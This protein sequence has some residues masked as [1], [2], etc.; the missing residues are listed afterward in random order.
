MHPSWTQ[1]PQNEQQLSTNWPK[2]LCARS[3]LDFGQHSVGAN[4]LHYSFMERTCASKDTTEV[5]WKLTEFVIL[6]G[7]SSFS[8]MPIAIFKGLISLSVEWVG[9]MRRPFL[10]FEG[11][12]MDMS[13]SWEG[14]EEP[15]FLFWRRVTPAQCFAHP[16][17]LINVI[18][19]CPW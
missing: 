3:C 5:L 11:K 12:D 13:C 17:H 2:S 16:D 9:A 14:T 15:Q 10:E 6:V 19:P 18:Y 4:Y 7:T 8:G 1:D